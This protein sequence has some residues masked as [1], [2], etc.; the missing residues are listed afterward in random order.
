MDS[1]SHNVMAESQLAG[2]FWLAPMHNEYQGKLCGLET[3]CDA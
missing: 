1:G 3:G 2:W